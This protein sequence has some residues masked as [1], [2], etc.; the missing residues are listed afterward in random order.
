[1]RL[2]ERLRGLSARWVLLGLAGLLVGAMLLAIALGPVSIP[3]GTVFSVLLHHI[4]GLDNLISVD[5]TS[6]EETIVWTLRLPRVL[7]AAAVGGGLAAAGVAMQGLFKNPLAD[8]YIVGISSGATL[9]ATIVLVAG[10]NVSE[11]AIG[12]VV[13]QLPA[14]GLGLVSLAAFLGALGVVGL[15]YRL[16]RTGTGLPLTT[17]LLAGLAMSALASALTAL[18]IYLEPEQRSSIFFWLMGGIRSSWSAVGF[19]LP[20]VAAGS[21]LLILWARDLDAL[22]LGDEQALF[23]GVEVERRKRHFLLVSTLVTAVGASFVGIIGFVGL[24]VPHILRTVLGPLHRLL[25][26]ASVLGGA[27]FLVLCD[28]IARTA[29]MGVEIP[30]GIIT[31]LAGTPFFLFLL[32]RSKAFGGAPQ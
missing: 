8:P 12:S 4:P 24:I 21:L 18:V 32:V 9:G 26:P 5:W 25:L 1:M 17:L 2:L 13:L 31:A 29:L 27:S 10:W 14:L 7:L 23:L 22:S 15:V 19:V 3:L 28:L 16:A 11:I 6:V 30:V 20:A